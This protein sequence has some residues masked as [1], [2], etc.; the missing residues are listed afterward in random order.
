MR[1]FVFQLETLTCPSCIRKIEAA[2]KDM[3]GVTEAEVRFHA[4]KVV[5]TC[6]DASVVDASALEERLTQ[7]GY[8]VIRWTMKEL[9][10]A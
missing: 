5:A 3:K 6:D 2:M 8:R 1:K 9:R 4:S 7:L 10:G